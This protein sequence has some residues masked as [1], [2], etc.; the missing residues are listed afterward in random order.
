MRFEP[1]GMTDDPDVRM[2]QSIMDYIFRR[3]ALDYLPL[4]DARRRSASTPPRSAPRQLE[5][6]SYEPVA[7]DDDDVEDDARGARAVGAGRRGADGRAPAPR[8]AGEAGAGR[9]SARR[10]SCSRR[11][12][13]PRRR[14]PA[15]HDLRHQDAPGRLLLRLRGLRQHQRLQ[16]M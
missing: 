5:T 8:R 10:P 7:D 1:A 9:R 4:R 6:G 2:A 15:V 13:G 16:L 11:M 12:H 14:R 3:L